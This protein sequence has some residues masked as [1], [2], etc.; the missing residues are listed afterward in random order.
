YFVNSTHTIDYAVEKVEEL[1]SRTEITI[2]KTGKMPMP[3]DVLVTY[4]N[5]DR[6][7]FNIPLDLMRGNKPNEIPEVKFTVLA[8]WPWTHPDYRIS[9]NRA[10]SE[11]SKIEIDPSKRMADMDV[12][13]NVWNK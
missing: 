13:N 12:E 9:I 11:I 2:K 4:A 3:L 8:D 1:S 10:Q 7:M 6:E 5:G